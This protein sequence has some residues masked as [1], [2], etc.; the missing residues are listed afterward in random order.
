[1]TTDL[2]G[3]PSFFGLLR[4]LRDHGAEFV[5]IGGLAVILHGA[6]R[7]TKDIDVVPEPSRAN[8]ARLWEALSKIE[9]TPAELP[10]FRPEEIPM[11]FTVDGLVEGGGN[12]VLHTNL[13]RIDVMQWVAGIDSYETLR[14]NAI[15]AEIPEAGGTVWFAGFEDLIEMKRAAGRDQDLMDITALRMAHGLEE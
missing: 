1:M 11:E 5:V 2:H 3:A 8:L 9:A 4:V 14:A 6:E 7:Y 13:G 12:W 15:A 10:D